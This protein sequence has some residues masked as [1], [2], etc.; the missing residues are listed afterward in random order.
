MRVHLINLGRTRSG[1]ARRFEFGPVGFQNGLKPDQNGGLVLEYWEYWT[2]TCCVELVENQPIGPAR[3]AI[4][5]SECRMRELGWRCAD[6]DSR[7]L[8]HGLVQD[9]RYNRRCSAYERHAR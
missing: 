6:A 7:R 3:T 8:E 2:E 1:V 4:A 9:Y 5:R